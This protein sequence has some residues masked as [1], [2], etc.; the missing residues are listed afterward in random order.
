MLSQYPDSVGHAD[1]VISL[2]R[3]GTEAGPLFA[4]STDIGD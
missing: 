1:R 4:K 3:T 2:P